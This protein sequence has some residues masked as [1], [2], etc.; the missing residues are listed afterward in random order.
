[1][2]GPQIDCP[3]HGDPDVNSLPTPQ[4]LCLL[5]SA[6]GMQGTHLVFLGADA[7][8]IA[9]TDAERASVQA[10]TMR[11]LVSC[12]LHL[13]LLEREDAAAAGLYAAR[14]MSGVAPEFDRWKFNRPETSLS[15]NPRQ[16]L[17]PGQGAAAAYNAMVDEIEILSAVL[18]ASGWDPKA[19]LRAWGRDA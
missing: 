6:L 15:P 13:K 11:G 12:S 18:V 8:T 1:M 16:K 9:H 10:G 3:V 4:E 7:F 5:Q 14:Y 2:D 19:V 17:L